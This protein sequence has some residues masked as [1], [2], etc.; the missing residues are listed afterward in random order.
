MRPALADGVLSPQDNRPLLAINPGHFATSP[1]PHYMGVRRTKLSV[2]DDAS[3][4]RAFHV[5][6]PQ[7]GCQVFE[8]AD[9]FEPFDRGG[10]GFVRAGD[11]A[12]RFLRRHTY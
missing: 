9:P 11:E 12:G 1:Y 7:T 6:M 2:G 8:E 4:T 5:L 10:V 3:A